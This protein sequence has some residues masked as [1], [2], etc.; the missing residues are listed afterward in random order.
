MVVPVVV[1]MDVVEVVIVVVLVVIVDV[2][3]REPVSVVVNVAAADGC[4][5]LGR[6]V[7]TLSL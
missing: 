5:L 1:V 3:V 2:L 6:S 7:G 4:L